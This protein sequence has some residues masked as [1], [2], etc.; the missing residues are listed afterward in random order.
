MQEGKQETYELGKFLRR[1]YQN[2]IGDQY[3]PDKVYIRSS[4]TDRA[5]MSAQCVAAG[6]FPPSGDEVWNVDLLWQPVPIHTIALADDI[7]LNSRV[8]CPFGEQDFY[9]NVY[10]ADQQSILQEHHSLIKFIEDNSGLK[11]RHS[12]DVLDI[13]N[14]LVAQMRRGLV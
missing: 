7:Y 4:D 14:V 10:S 3:S 9:R 6:L 1:R 5:L 11:L 12:N 13:Y 8:K 2:L